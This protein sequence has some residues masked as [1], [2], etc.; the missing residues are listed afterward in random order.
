MGSRNLFIRFYGCNMC[1]LY[2]DTAQ[3]SYKTFTKEG[4]LGKVLDFE[5]GYNE[6]SITGGE[7]L[8]YADFLKEF[9]PLFRRH[10]RN[11]VY[12]ETNGTL[13][14]KLEAVSSL[15]DI[16]CM[17]IKLPSSSGAPESVLE[18]HAR[19]IAGCADRDLVIKAVIT[20]LTTI[21][22]IKKMARLLD[23][24]EGET[25]VVLQPVTVFSGSPA[26]ADEEMMLLFREYLKKETGKNAV[27]L[28]QM[29]K[30]AGIR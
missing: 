5:D 17:D 3:K 2:C 16:V 29:H 24:R 14:E 25:S 20:G 13:P 12:L 21:D 6:L 15:V 19:F 10:R 23:L 22:D 27:I 26:G 30:Y 28:G 7:P 4:L 18:S 8:L 1:C 11:K 9:L